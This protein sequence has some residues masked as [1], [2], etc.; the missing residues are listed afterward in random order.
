MKTSER[1]PAPFFE[2][3]QFRQWW[4]WATLVP[5]TLGTVGIFAYG[6]IRQL[7][8]GRPFGDHPMPDTALAI[9]GPLT[10]L[11]SLGVLWLMWATKLEIQVRPDGVHVRFFPFLRRYLRFGQIRSCEACTY[12]PIREYGGWG[13]RIRRGKRAYSVSGNQG[14]QLVLDDGKQ[15]LLGSLRSEELARAIQA[16]LH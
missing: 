14:V 11:I 1:N 13:V 3:Q 2:V 8:L 9:F 5:V 7:G 4:V 10:M 16:H 15:L 6:M 12:H